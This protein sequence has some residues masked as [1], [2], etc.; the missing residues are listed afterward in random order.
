MFVSLSAT[1]S[2]ATN[3]VSAA[4]AR[5]GALSVFATMSTVETVGVVTKMTK[6]LLITSLI[7][8]LSAVE[9]DTNTIC[10]IPSS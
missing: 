6:V 3:L 9:K 5:K 7:D 2:Q 10:K 8:T 1:A 4:T